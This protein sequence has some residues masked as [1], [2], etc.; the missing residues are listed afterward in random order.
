MSGRSACFDGME[1]IS[2]FFLDEK[3]KGRG[4]A[5]EQSKQS[6][7]DGER[8]SHSLRIE[9]LLVS[10]RAERRQSRESKK[11]RKDKLEGRKKEGG[12][13]VSQ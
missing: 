6:F 13:G 9:R 2:S 8:R 11:G 5:H 12:V 3:R 4:A 7:E 10:L 1:T